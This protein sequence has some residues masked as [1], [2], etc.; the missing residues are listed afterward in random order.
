MLARQNGRSRTPVLLVD[1]RAALLDQEA[2]RFERAGVNGAVQS[3]AAAPIQRRVPPPGG[4]ALHMVK[5][6]K[7]ARAQRVDILTGG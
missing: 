5:E 6:R 1:G 2:H 3:G 4:G 7:V